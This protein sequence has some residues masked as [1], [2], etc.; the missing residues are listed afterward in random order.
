[1]P[2]SFSGHVNFFKNDIGFMSNDYTSISYIEILD[3]DT[4]SIEM[5]R[6]KIVIR[7]SLENKF[8]FINFFHT[9]WSVWDPRAL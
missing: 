3:T 5:P 7:L 4:R 9:V 6:I 2:V 8:Y 1:M